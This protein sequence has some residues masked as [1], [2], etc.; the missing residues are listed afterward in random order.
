[1]QLIPVSSSGLHLVHCDSVVKSEPVPSVSSLTSQPVA[2]LVGCTVNE[3]KLSYVE[4]KLAVGAE[5]FTVPATL[6]FT[7]AGQHP[8][9]HS[10]GMSL[11][12]YSSA[13]PSLVMSTNDSSSI[14]RSLFSP[15]IVDVRSLKVKVEPEDDKF[16]STPCSA[17]LDQ[18]PA[19][20]RSS[21]SK[22]E[23]VE[24]PTATTVHCSDVPFHPSSVSSCVTSGCSSS[25]SL[26]SSSEV[27][28][29]PLTSFAGS[30]PSEM[31]SSTRDDKSVACTVIKQ[32]FSPAVDSCLSSVK[33][34]A[35]T[36]LQPDGA[37]LSG[38]NS[39]EI[40]VSRRSK[41]TDRTAECSVTRSEDVHLSTPAKSA[42]A[43][44]V[45]SALDKAAV[46]TDS[47]KSVYSKTA[48]TDSSVKCK[49][50][51]SAA[52]LKHTAE[53]GDTIVRQSGNEC[54]LSPMISTVESRKR[55]YE[56][57]AKTGTYV[58]GHRFI[59]KV[60]MFD[61]RDLRYTNYKTALNF[62]ACH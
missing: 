15:A 53:S 40:P 42:K 47:R 2:E 39:T 37:H 17:V 9:S 44:D 25:S 11:N 29:R 20:S 18:A 14:S 38:R 6:V 35:S 50:L 8:S 7:V 31:T 19:P 33:H 62:E 27:S 4:T 13:V 61:C 46:H 36:A 34:L 21:F 26:I 10:D 32:E 1:L 43:V 23:S 60:V 30:L 12:L 58:S 5:Q 28:L 59:K 49:Q 22:C 45:V 48:S 56:P 16:V 55:K 54:K 41:F 24:M 57:T 3:E 52:E 51:P